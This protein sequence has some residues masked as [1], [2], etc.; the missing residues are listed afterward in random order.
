MKFL[1]NTQLFF[2]FSFSKQQNIAI[3]VVTYRK[4]PV[5]KMLW[6]SDKKL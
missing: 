4:M 6:N 1:H 3:E 2:F 5:T